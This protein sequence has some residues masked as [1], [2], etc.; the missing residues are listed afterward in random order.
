MN[1]VLLELFWTRVQ[2]PPPPPIFQLYIGS[3]NYNKTIYSIKEYA[4]SVNA[5]DQFGSK[6]T[7]KNTKDCGD[8]YVVKQS[9]SFTLDK[10][11][12]CQVTFY[13]E[14]MENGTKTVCKIETITLG[15]FIIAVSI[16]ER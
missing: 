15:F 12:Y 5:F 16:N 6:I 7:N 1:D 8:I 11:I 3:L 14:E 13:N 2:L 4:E 10:N 9:R